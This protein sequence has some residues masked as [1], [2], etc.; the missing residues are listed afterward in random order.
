[1]SRGI[2]LALSAII[3]ICAVEGSSERIRRASMPLM[4]GR[5]MSIR[6]T[7]GREASATSTPRLPSAALRRRMSLRRAMRSST[8]IRLAGLS[9]T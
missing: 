3:G 6:I 1:M 5:L 8:S 9:S 2:A 7:S 4:P